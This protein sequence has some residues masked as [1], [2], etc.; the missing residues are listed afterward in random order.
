MDDNA[1]TNIYVSGDYVQQKN[2]YQFGYIQPGAFCVQINQRPNTPAA[3]NTPKPKDYNAVRE[4]VKERMLQDV[5]FKEYWNNHKW[6]ERA[7]YLTNIFGWE[8]D[9]HSLNV[10]WNRNT[11]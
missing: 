5:A 3:T 7:E 8:V 4:Y 1:K 2:E 11:K 9:E 10:N 6:I